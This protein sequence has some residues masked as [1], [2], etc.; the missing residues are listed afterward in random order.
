[1]SEAIQM[2]DLSV[3]VDE[4]GDFGPYDYHTP[5][6]IVTL[7][8]HDQDMDVTDAIRHFERSLTEMDLPAQHIV[9]AGPLIRR[10]ELYLNMSVDE[11]KK[12]FNRAFN[13]LRTTEIAYKAFIVEK[14][15]IESSLDLVAALSKQLTRFFQKHY[16]Y[17]TRYDRV[18]LYYDNGQVELTKMLVSLL[19]AFFSRVEHRQAKPSNYRLLQAA[20]IICTMVLTELKAQNAMLSKSEL[21]F[22]V[23]YRELKKNYLKALKRKEFLE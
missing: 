15:H 17:F 7:V 22:F 23:S 1:M 12:I 13:F 14:K 9:H 8:F 6:Y 16:A 10:E 20:D 2:K 18:I 5:Y 11:R 19:H 3:F 4:S 21:S